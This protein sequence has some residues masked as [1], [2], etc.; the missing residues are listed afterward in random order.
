[1]KKQFYAITFVALLIFAL[2]GCNDRTSE[3]NSAIIRDA[4]SSFNLIV[5]N[6]LENK[7]YHEALNHF[8]LLL[9]DGD[10][11]EWTE[12][13]SVSDADFSL[14]INADEFVNA[15]LDVT[16]LGGTPFTYV[17]ASDNNPNMLIYKFDVSSNKEIYKDSNEAFEKL[18]SQIPEQIAVLENDGYILSLDQGFQV[19]WNADGRVNKD[20]AFVVGAE[21]LVKAGLNVDKLNEWKVMKNKDPN[22]TQLKLLKIYYLK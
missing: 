11:F 22:D 13:P 2:T 18:L 1:M 4:A 19:H 10:K 3:N 6:N 21:D 20:M 15:G 16:K 9:K 8:G 7:V 12:D 14:S 17:A 5:T